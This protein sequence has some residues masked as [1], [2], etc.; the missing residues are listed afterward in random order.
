MQESEWPHRVAVGLSP[1]TRDTWAHLAWTVDRTNQV[2][3]VYKNGV[4]ENQQNIAILGTNAV[5][6]N[7]ALNFGIAATGSPFS[8]SLDNIAVYDFVLQP[9]DIQ[10][11]CKA[12][13]GTGTCP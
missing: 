13:T 10:A 7:D 11:R 2:M 5:T 1:L 8:G 3:K 12:D 4:Y 9:A 6:G